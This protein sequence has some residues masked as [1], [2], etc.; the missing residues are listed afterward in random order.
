MEVKIISQNEVGKTFEFTSED[1]AGVTLVVNKAFDDDSDAHFLVAAIPEIPILGIA[2]IQYPI[3][4]DTEEQR[5]AA[6]DDEL[7]EAW[8][9]SFLSQLANS[10]IENRQNPNGVNM[11]NTE[12]SE[13]SEN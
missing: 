12:I 13:A 10:I 4:F 8:A 5:N 11:G 6:F 9:L 1:Y 2:N 3:K 7:N